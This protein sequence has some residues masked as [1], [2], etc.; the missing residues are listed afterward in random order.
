VTNP[1]FGVLFHAIGGFAAG[2]FYSPLRK[3]QRWAWESYWLIMGIA[4]WV[5]S[6]ILMATITTP[7]L[8]EVFR[9]S[10]SKNLLLAYLFG[11]LWG[12]GGLTFG[13]TMRYLGISLGYAMALGL[14]AVFG[15]LMPPIWKGT[16]GSLFANTSGITILSGLV[17]CIL[18]IVICGLA[19]RR[20]E[21]ELS[22]DQKKL[23][24]KEYALGKGLVVAIICG[25]LSA[26]FAFGL[27]MGKP[28]ASVA[29]SMGTKSLYSNNS[30][31]V[32]ILAG[33]F[34]T[35]LI[36]CLSLN[37][38]NRTLA[39]YVSGSFFHQVH[40]YSLS[41]LSGVRTTKLGEK[42][43]FS[44]WSLHMAFII[45]FSNLWGLYFH[46]WRDVSRTTKKLIW[47]GIFALVASTMVIGVG[48]YL[49]K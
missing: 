15:T 41:V 14:C 26:C 31:L 11:V 39:N 8:W 2:S 13:L 44:S 25:V 36:W 49:A 42:Y 9:N 47:I 24:T 35:N 4:A 28:I 45:V 19:G 18:G 10:P 12:I 38:Y 23:T 22:D 33:G 43:D 5:I 3:V 20:K 48:N 37:I 27:E 40:N 30:V 29:I 46:E 34:T 7:H 17:V 16:I 21:V 1:F 32:V 6:P